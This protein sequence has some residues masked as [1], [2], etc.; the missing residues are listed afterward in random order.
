MNQFVQT[1]YFSDVSVAGQQNGGLAEVSGSL[2]HSE[3]GV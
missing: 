3:T 2:I 1:F